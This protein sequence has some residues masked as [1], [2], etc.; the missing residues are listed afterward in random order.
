MAHNKKIWFQLARDTAIDYCPELARLNSISRRRCRDYL[1]PAICKRWNVTWAHFP[2]EQTFYDAIRGDSCGCVMKERFAI[3]HY[4]L[5]DK[6]VAAQMPQLLTALAD[7]E[8]NI[9]TPYYHRFA[10]EYKKEKQKP[11]ARLVL[12]EPFEPV[13][14][15]VKRDSKKWKM[16]KEA[17]KKIDREEK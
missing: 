1:L 7:K 16:L 6:A 14:R 4:A 3:L 8:R 13:L 2:G 9:P 10:E 15:E 12:P 11:H 5:T 17:I